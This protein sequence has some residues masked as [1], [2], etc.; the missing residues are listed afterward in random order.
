[1]SAQNGHVNCGHC[2]HLHEVEDLHVEAIL[3][4]EGASD[5][6]DEALV[7]GLTCSS[8]GARGVLVA[9]YGPTADPIEAAVVSRL[10]D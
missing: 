6:A 7:A 2:G 5:P 8:C 1:M 10:G 4:I 3:R 9:G